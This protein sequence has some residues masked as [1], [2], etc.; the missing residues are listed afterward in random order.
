MGDELGLLNDGSYKNDP[1]KA[2]DSRWI[3]RPKMDWKT[4]KLR[5]NNSTPTGKLFNGLKNLAISR[6]KSVAL[7]SQARTTA[8]WSHNDHVFAILRQSARGKLL[9]LAN[10]SPSQQAV[11]AYRLSEMGFSGELIDQLTGQGFH[12]KVDVQLAGYEAI[13]LMEKEKE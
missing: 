7:H 11:P 6:K 12:T 3:H 2:A 9:L 13:W 4:A 5:Q 1:E 10:F 8:E